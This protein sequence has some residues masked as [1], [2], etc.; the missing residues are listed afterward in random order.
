MAT[1]VRCCK[2]SHAHSLTSNSRGRCLA[3]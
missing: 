1:A 2:R 3:S